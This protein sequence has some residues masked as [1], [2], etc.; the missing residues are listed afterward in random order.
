MTT[1]L[2]NVI[3]SDRMRTSDYGRMLELVRRRVH[4]R[5]AD[6]WTRGITIDLGFASVHNGS[7][8]DAGE[9]SDYRDFT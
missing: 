8:F 6:G 4:S 5:N 3:K 9:R 2:F 7:A 1:R